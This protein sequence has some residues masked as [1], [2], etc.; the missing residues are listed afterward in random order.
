MLS[1]DTHHQTRLKL[2]A[3]V[4]LPAV[5]Q[6]TLNSV[7]RLVLVLPSLYWHIRVQQLDNDDILAV[8]Y[9]VSHQK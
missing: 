2:N 5:M 6:A 7:R 9:A 8:D 3:M 4:I 1:R